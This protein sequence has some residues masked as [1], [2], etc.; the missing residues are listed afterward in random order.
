MISKVNK[1]RTKSQLKDYAQ[2]VFDL[3]ANSVGELNVTEKEES[4]I[5]ELASSC[6]GFF[7]NQDI[8]DILKILRSKKLL[9][10]NILEYSRIHKVSKSNNPDICEAIK[11]EVEELTCNISTKH[12][13]DNGEVISSYEANC[14][15]IPSLKSKITIGENISNIIYKKNGTGILPDIVKNS[16]PSLDFSINN[17][18]ILHKKECTKDDFKEFINI[19]IIPQL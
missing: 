14:F 5:K 11:G 8:F 18:I 16:K 6:I 9:T 1:F 7:S 3:Y 2:E 4:F 17:L 10:D 15:T 12:L 19:I 13:K